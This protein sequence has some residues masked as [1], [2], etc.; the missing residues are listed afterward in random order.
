MSV[1]TNKREVD[2]EEIAC[3]YLINML[4]GFGIKDFVV[5]TKNFDG[6]IVLDI[7]SKTLGFVIGKHGSVIDAMQYLSTLVVN[8]IS[9]K[10]YKVKINANRYREKKE[11]ALTYIAKK[12]CL[13]AKETGKSVVLNAMNAYDRRLVH[14]AVEEES[15]VISYSQGSKANRH[16]VIALDNK[17]SEKK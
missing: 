8:S 16:V 4:K 3:S 1:L 17:K 13:E 7:K 9:P 11:L 15:G 10:Y 5:Q 14:V 6:G 12:A 2:L